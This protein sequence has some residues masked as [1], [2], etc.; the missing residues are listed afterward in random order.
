MALL[1]GGGIAVSLCRLGVLPAA[2]WPALRGFLRVMAAGAVLASLSGL[3]L[4][5]AYPA[6]AL[7]NPVFAMKFACLVAAALLLRVPGRRAAAAGA[8]LWLGGV[9]AGK[10][11]LHTAKVL[12]VS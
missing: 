5:V 7:T 2:Q 9:A 4:L 6:K 10:L 1:V 11:L 12:T 3:V 8:L